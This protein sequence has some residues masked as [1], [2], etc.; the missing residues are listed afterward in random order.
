M[1]RKELTVAVGDP[2][3]LGY[4]L[5]G[6]LAAAGGGLTSAELGALVQRSGRNAY[7]PRSTPSFARR[8]AAASPA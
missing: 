5:L 6:F 2:G 4:P 1:A 3:G 8:F 7:V